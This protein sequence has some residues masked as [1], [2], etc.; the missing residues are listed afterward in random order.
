MKPLKSAQPLAHWLIRLA[1]VAYLVLLFLPQLY[2][3]NLKSINFYIATISI[4]LA[5]TLFIGGFLS[6]SSITVFSGL[7]VATLF[8]Y[9]FVKDFTGVITHSTMIY[10]LPAVLGFYFFSR[11]NKT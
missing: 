7:G 3:I 2:P 6:S 4:I 9:L 10:F 8:I 1:L 5:I 11:G